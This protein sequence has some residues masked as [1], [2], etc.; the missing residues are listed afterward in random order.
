MGLPK[1]VAFASPDSVAP[2][3]VAGGSTNSA[4]PNLPSFCLRLFVTPCD[5]LRRRSFPWQRS[6]IAR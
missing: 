6:T 3:H 5:I 2:Y 4:A 1:T